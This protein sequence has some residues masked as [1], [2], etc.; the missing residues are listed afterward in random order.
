[1]MTG[2]DGPIGPGHRPALHLRARQL[3][4]RPAQHDDP[5]EASARGLDLDDVSGVQRIEPR[6]AILVRDDERFRRTREL[7]ARVGLTPD[8][9]AACGTVH[10]DDH[11]AGTLNMLGE[12]LRH[13]EASS[14]SS[15]VAIF[16]K[17]YELV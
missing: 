7:G 3:I 6:A 4:P 5:R 11:Q 9:Q 12:A 10:F 16:R 14:K 13:A 2:L 17:S 8:A 15:S 1:M